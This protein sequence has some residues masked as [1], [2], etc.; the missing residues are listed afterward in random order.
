MQRYPIVGI[1]KRNRYQMKRNS[2]I[3]NCINTAYGLSN[4]EIRFLCLIWFIC[5][6]AYQTIIGYLMPIFDTF[7]NV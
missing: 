3:F 7:V 6:R 4:A 5:L 2:E 1:V